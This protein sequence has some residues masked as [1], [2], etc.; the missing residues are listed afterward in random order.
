MQ[1]KRM[2]ERRHALSWILCTVLIVAVALIATGCSGKAGARVETLAA[3]DEVQ[4]VGKGGRSF[5]FSV[6]DLEGNE[7]N[8]E[9]HTDKEMVGE[10][11]MEVGLLE[12][13]AGPYGLF[14]KAVN[15]ISADFDKDKVY[16]AFYVNGEY[17]MTGVD[18]TEIKEG[19][20]YSFR[21]EK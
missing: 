15:G 7:A 16:W 13:E 1:M 10:A 21:I 6:V 11:L 14:V 19:E 3:S 20:T 12:G 17:G 18:M 4:V 2:T 8:F 5:D 9:V